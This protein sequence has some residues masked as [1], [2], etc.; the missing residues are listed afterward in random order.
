VKKL[1]RS[2][3]SGDAYEFVRDLLLKGDR[4]NPGD[5]I[6]VEEL[7]R[8]LGVSRTP[9]WGAINRLEAE[10]IVEIVPRQGVYL[11]D[12]NPRKAVEIY[13]AREALEGMAAR[14]AAGKVTER[15]LAWLTANIAEQKT[16]LEKGDI[17][18]YS[19]AAMAFHEQIVKI[20]NNKTLERLFASIY[21]Q[22]RAMRVQ[23]KYFPTHLPQSCEDHNRLLEALRRG[24]PNL[25]EQEA[26]QHIQMLRAEIAKGQVNVDAK[27]TE[28]RV[29][30]ASA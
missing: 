27:K 29:S 17:E 2:N 5:K 30:A 24:D 14:L 23:M 20:A 4:Y 1:R 10:G 3:L 16:C 22:I 9:L 6:S 12:F 11:I 25:A 26:R 7:S 15:H 8:E 21:A 28:R 18:G 19:A 13:F